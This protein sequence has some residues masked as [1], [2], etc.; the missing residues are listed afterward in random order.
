MRPGSTW[1]VP[2]NSLSPSSLSYGRFKKHTNPRNTLKKKKFNKCKHYQ[3][4]LHK[5]LPDMFCFKCFISAVQWLIRK[6]E[7]WINCTV[8]FHVL[9]Q[10][11]GNI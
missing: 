1:I 5:P 4:S 9:G 7:S 10:K 11:I 8:F 6:Y 2:L 3:L